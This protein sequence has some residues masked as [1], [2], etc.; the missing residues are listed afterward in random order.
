MKHSANEQVPA[1]H[2]E[3][4]LYMILVLAIFSLFLP[5]FFQIRLGPPL[6]VGPLRSA[7]GLGSD[8]AKCLGAQV[9]R[10][11]KQ[12]DGGKAEEFLDV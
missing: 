12:A 11:M 9:P 3:L 2:S 4:S 1:K 6:P 7:A 8:Y 10:A 5:H